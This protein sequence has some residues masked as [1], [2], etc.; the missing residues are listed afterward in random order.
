MDTLHAPVYDDRW[1]SY[2]NPTHLRCVE[3]L[4]ERVPRDGLVLDA[5][6]GTG[7]YWQT[8]LDA[9]VRVTGIDHSRAMLRIASAKHPSVP[10]AHTSLQDLRTRVDLIRAMDGLVC[11]DALENVGPEDWPGVIDG[12]VGV[13]RPGAPAYL[14][15]ELPE[16]GT[17]VPG[18]EASP[19]AVTEPLVAG[20]VLE[21]GAY[22][23]YPS[24]DD[25]RA[26][27]TGH[28]LGVWSETGGD[29]YH[30]FLVERT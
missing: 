17:A 6:C 12:L 15:V 18:Q 1:G 29:G 5:A 19:E 24:V 13:L 7:K 4:L 11:I 3:A 8:F 10:V 14:T 28:G 9:G 30:H 25:A 16:E 20:E 22:H 23:Y 26:W 21:D 2:L 27:I